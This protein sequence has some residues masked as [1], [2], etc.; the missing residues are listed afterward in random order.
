M[1]SGVKHLAIHCAHP[2]PL[3]I[4]TPSR[5]GFDSSR[6]RARGF[7][8]RA[9]PRFGGFV[10]ACVAPHALALRLGEVRRAAMSRDDDDRRVRVEAC[11]RS[12]ADRGRRRCGSSIDSSLGACCGSWGY[13]KPGPK[14]HVRGSATAHCLHWSPIAFIVTSAIGS[15]TSR[16][17]FSS[18]W[19]IVFSCCKRPTT[20]PGATPTLA[21]KAVTV[22]AENAP[23]AT[24]LAYALGEISVSLANSSASCSWSRDPDEPFDDVLSLLRDRARACSLRRPVTVER[25]FVADPAP[26]RSLLL[27]LARASSVRSTC[28]RSCACTRCGPRASLDDTPRG[29]D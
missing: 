7:S 6:P 21:A 19:A 14:N 25:P 15:I 9:H 28:R 18:E 17:P 16:S 11:Q 10:R 23:R 26:S 24:K 20:I 22:A 29:L 8:A 4:R 5:R 13:L 12:V 1:R 27:S 2:C 3:R